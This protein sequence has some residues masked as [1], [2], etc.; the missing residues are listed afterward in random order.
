MGWELGGLFG[1][2]GLD[3]RICWGFCGWATAIILFRLWGV[4]YE[5]WAGVCGENGERGL[6]G[7]E[8][9]RGPSTARCAPA[10]KEDLQPAPIRRTLNTTNT[11]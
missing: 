9:Y 8:R 10:C 1:V 11:V 6:R 5:L 2:E 3:T 4:G 7:C